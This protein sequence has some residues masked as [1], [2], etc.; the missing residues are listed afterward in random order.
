LSLEKNSLLSFSLKTT[1]LKLLNAKEKESRRPYRKDTSQFS[2]MVK[3]FLKI[4]YY[5][6]NAPPTVQKYKL[7]RKVSLG[8]I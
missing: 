5:T 6:K 4:P 1:I 7:G 3:A 8:Y 2:V